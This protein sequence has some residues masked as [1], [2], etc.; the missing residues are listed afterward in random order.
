MSRASQNRFNVAQPKV[1]RKTKTSAILEG[2]ALRAHD[3]PL[4]SQLRDAL[5]RLFWRVE[6][7]PSDDVSYARY[8]RYHRLRLLS[9]AIANSTADW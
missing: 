1:Q 7:A 8:Q 2:L 3:V 6:P 9:D 4:A 5:H